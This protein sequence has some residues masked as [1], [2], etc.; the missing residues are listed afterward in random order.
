[1]DAVGGATFYLGGATHIAVTT[2]GS[3][4]ILRR[5]QGSTPVDYVSLQAVP[6]HSLAHSTPILSTA[7]GNMKQMALHGQVYAPNANFVF[8]NVTNSAAAQLLGGAVVGAIEAQ[9]S[10]SASGFLIQVQGSPQ[11][12]R[13][14][15]TAIATKAG[16]TTRVQV[17]AQLR[18]TAA[19]AAAG[20]GYWELAVNSWRVCDTVC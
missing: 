15:L 1:M 2:Q 4:E 20:T 5:E 9:A 12:D 11:A 18:F 7:S 6:S 10:A 16:I 8:G 17:I 19:S 13:M 3:L 14:R